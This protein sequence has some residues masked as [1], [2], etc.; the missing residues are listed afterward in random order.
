MMVAMITE[1]KLQEMYYLK[2]RFIQ[3]SK[4]DP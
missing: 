3:S 4:V 1:Q 2:H